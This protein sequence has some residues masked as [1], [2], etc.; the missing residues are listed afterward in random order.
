ML[1]RIERAPQEVDDFLPG[2]ILR[3]SRKP[4]V[5]CALQGIATCNRVDCRATGSAAPACSLVRRTAAAREAAISR[6]GF[7][8]RRKAVA[9]SNAMRRQME[10]GFGRV[11]KPDLQVARELRCESTARP[12]EHVEK[13]LERRQEAAMVSAAGAGINPAAQRS[14][15]ERAGALFPV[16]RRAAAAR[17]IRPAVERRSTR[18]SYLLGASPIYSQPLTASCTPAAARV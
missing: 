6:M 10:R 11:G 13:L 2:T 8:A 9:V 7:L 1:F 12:V 15:P 18:R 16:V 14:S 4:Y 5:D 3:S 17:A